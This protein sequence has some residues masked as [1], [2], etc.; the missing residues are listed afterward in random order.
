MK[1]E[2]R[3]ERVLIAAI[4]VLVVVF[5][6]CIG[7]FVFRSAGK[8][9]NFGGGGGGGFVENS[10]SAGTG[11][12]LDVS[13][14]DIAVGDSDNS[15]V[16]YALAGELAETVNLADE[17]GNTVMKMHDDGADGDTAAGDGIYSARLAINTNAPGNYHYR[18]IVNSQRQSEEEIL[19][20]VA[21]LTENDIAAMQSADQ[22]LNAARKSSANRAERQKALAASLQQLETEGLIQAGSAVTDEDSGITMFYY[23]CGVLGGV[24]ADDFS[25][26]YAAPSTSESL[27]DNALSCDALVPESLA[28][29][30]QP[31]SSTGN[32]Q[33]LYAFG[34]PW[35]NGWNMIYS[36]CN[37][38]RESWSQN[39]LQ[40]SLTTDL[41]LEDMQ[42]IKNQQFVYVAAHGAS[43]TFQYQP[44]EN[45]WFFPYMTENVTVPGVFLQENVSAKRDRKYALG[46]QTGRVFKFNNCYGI[47]PAFFDEHYR[48]NSFQDCLFYWGSCQFMGRGDTVDEQ[49][50]EVLSSKSVK[51]FVAFHNS[52][53]IHYHISFLERLMNG[54]LSGQTI[55]EAFASATELC[56]ENSTAWYNLPHQEVWW[57]D[58]TQSLET[59]ALPRSGESTPLLRGDYEARLGSTQ[60]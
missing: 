6:A 37:A 33:I 31:G 28:G 47:V 24:Q 36:R 44:D 56:G 57:A 51:A 10:P 3:G 13:R 49:W 59:E 23:A 26:L 53:Y 54:L 15:V 32:A 40:T 18:A 41:T 5:A 11:F 39:G 38:L 9:S 14:H 16:F 2:K 42:S 35:E 21:P 48:Y 58:F 4:A 1:C 12:E 29:D 27:A 20:V 43:L 30:W 7:A 25:P 55:R 17:N 22:A 45:K 46:L 34:T 50:A 60:T 8:K 19:H 52:N